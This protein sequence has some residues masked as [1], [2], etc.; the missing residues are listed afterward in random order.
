MNI[1]EVAQKLKELKQPQF[2]LKQ[3]LRCY[4]K[5]LKSDWSEISTWPKDLRDAMIDQ[6]WSSLKLVKTLET[7]DPPSVKMLLKTHDSHHIETVIM[8]HHDGRNTVCISSQVGCAMGCLFCATGKMGYTR[9]LTAQEIVDQIIQAARILSAQ[10]AKVTNIVFMGMG[11]PFNNPDEV[12]KA[13]NIIMDPEA[14]GLGARH[15]SISTCGIIPGI[16]RLMKECPQVN[17]AI[18]LHAPNQVLRDRIMPVSKA[19]PL[20]KLMNTLKVYADAT[21]RKI[22]FEYV[23]LDGV[24]DSLDHADE[25]ADLL[26]EFRG[27]AHVNLIK[28]HQTGAFKASNESRRRHFQNQLKRRGISVTHRISYGEEINAACGQLSAAS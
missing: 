10:S 22:M 4:Y 28:Y 19:Y 11:E 3:A 8:R 14:I 20:K 23:M 15:I 6:P 17:L 7:Q 12:F 13:L 9:N 24:N 16:N 21:H 5:D 25:L 27:L 26:M 1:A 18:S 2:R